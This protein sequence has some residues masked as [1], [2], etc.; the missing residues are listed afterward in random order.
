MS[1]MLTIY[2]YPDPVL[3]AKAQPVE[4][5]DGNLQE[6]IDAMTETMYRM[7]PCKAIPAHST[8]ARLVTA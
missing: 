4:N 1:D 7:S 8:T 6:L 3:R 5:I 2:K